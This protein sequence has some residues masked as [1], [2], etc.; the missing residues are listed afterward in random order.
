MY[1]IKFLIKIKIEA[2]FKNDN[3]III[4]NKIA[5]LPLC[6]EVDLQNLNIDN[7]IQKYLNLYIKINLNKST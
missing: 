3:L 5:V 2:L 1:M 7:E 4:D 6:K